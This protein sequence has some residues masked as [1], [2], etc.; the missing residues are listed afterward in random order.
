MQTV[1][2]RLALQEQVMAKYLD[3]Y[4]FNLRCAAP[5]YIVTF[6]SVNQTA[7]V[8]IAITERIRCD[9]PDFIKKHGCNIGPEII[10]T[11]LDVPV[12]FPRAGGYVMT[13][14]VNP[15]DECLIVF[16]DTCIDAWYEY[17]GIQ[18]QMD[19][20]RHD[21]S[22]AIA[23]MGIWSQPKKIASWSTSAVQLRNETGNHYVEITPTGLNLVF[24]ST[25]IEMSDS[26]IVITG[27]VL[28]NNHLTVEE[29][30]TLEDRVWLNH[31][32]TGVQ[33]G[34]GNTGGVL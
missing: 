32:H 26:G 17:G 13:F 27:N 30:T 7:E 31:Q 6:D 3:G 23:V 10:P 4:D 28:M 21:L 24:G 34:G 14:P 18:N 12:C 9:H 8:Q 1:S 19:M 5:G 25:K 33:P 20:R 2:E 29:L 15:G 22:D 11:L 16:A